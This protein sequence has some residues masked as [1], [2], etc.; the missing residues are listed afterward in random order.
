MQSCFRCLRIPLTT[1]IQRVCTH[2]FS[3]IRPTKWSVD[4]VVTSSRSPHYSNYYQPSPAGNQPFK[5]SYI[6]YIPL[7]KW[8]KYR[9]QTERNTVAS[10]KEILSTVREPPLPSRRVADPVRKLCPRLQESVAATE[11]EAFCDNQMKFV[12]FFLFCNNQRE[13]QVRFLQVTIVPSSYVGSFNCLLNHFSYFIFWL[14]SSL[15]G[16]HRN[17]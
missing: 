17:K 14:S 2:Q 7:I 16:W 10:W 6:Q 12:W 3:R 4:P 9:W 13:S 1:R 11:A 8:A 15:K 5:T